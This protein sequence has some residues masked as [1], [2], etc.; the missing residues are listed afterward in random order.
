MLPLLV[1]GLWFLTGCTEETLNPTNTSEGRTLPQSNGGR[2]DFIVVAEDALWDGIAGDLL[3]KHF[4]APQYGLPQPEPVFTLRQVS[5][6]EFNDLLRHSRNL[7]ILEDKADSSFTITRDAWA[8]PQLVSSFTGNE[9]QIAKTVKEVREQ[10]YQTYYQSEV[11][12]MLKRLQPAR[13]KTLPK[14]LQQNGVQD[15]VIN[16]AFEVEHA[17]D[18]LVVMWN[19]TVKS[20]QGIIAYFRPMKENEI[21]ETSLLNTRDSLVKHFI[22]GEREGSYMVT[23]TI[24][25]PKVSTT[26]IDGKLAF[27]TR[28]LW[29]TVGDFKG[30]P[31]INFTLLDEEN[32]RVIVLEAFVFAP[33]LKKRNLLFELECMLRSIKLG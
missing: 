31:F 30:G 32:Q 15:M 16:R 18:S 28:G 2:L 4:I 21:V 6:A 10:L 3:R 27:E 13:M 17:Y 11:N 25:P 8:K 1:C 24:L 5:P 14:V 29:R 9:M 26:T 12:M 19:K 7:I 33:E 22:P 20:D 23:E